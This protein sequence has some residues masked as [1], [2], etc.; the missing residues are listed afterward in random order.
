MC[1]AAETSIVQV[2]EL[3]E[4]GQ[5]DPEVV[6]TPGIF[7]QRLVEIPEPQQESVLVKEGRVYP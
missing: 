5:I 7:V 3:V 2:R 1:T 4:L 6:V